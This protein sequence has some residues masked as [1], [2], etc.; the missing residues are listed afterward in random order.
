MR[1]PGPIVTPS[2]SLSAAPDRCAIQPQSTVAT[3]LL[4]FD[5][6][7][8]ILKLLLD[9]FGLSLVDAFL[10]RLRR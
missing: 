3:R 7:A 5:G 9:L 6:R 10:D 4:E 1:P 2:V 8:G